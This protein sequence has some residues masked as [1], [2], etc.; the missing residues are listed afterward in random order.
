MARDRRHYQ[1][2]STGAKSVGVTPR[3][4]RWGRPG[5]RRQAPSS[6]TGRVRRPRFGHPAGDAPAPTRGPVIRAPR[7]PAGRPPDRRRGPLPRHPAR[8]LP[9]WRPDQGATGSPPSW[10]GARRV[11]DAETVRRRREGERAGDRVS[12]GADDAVG[13]GVPAPGER[14]HQRLGDGAAVDLRL[15]RGG[16]R[17]TGPGHLHLDEVGV[18][19][20][21]E[22]Q[23]HLGQ[24]SRPC[25]RRPGSTPRGAAVRDER[26]GRRTANAGAT[27]TTARASTSTTVTTT[28]RRRDGIPASSQRHRPAPH[29]GRRARRG[30]P[31]PC[32]ASLQVRGSDDVG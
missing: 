16:L 4:P 3:G 30:R 20:L 25:C 21:G 2:P 24:R 10:R 14:L 29:R 9:R 23:R 12:V 17:A 26:R 6:W 1:Q 15:V 8:I 27:A 28:A 7:R 31:N 32:P 5:P 22:L 19:V 11:G 18:D 13:H